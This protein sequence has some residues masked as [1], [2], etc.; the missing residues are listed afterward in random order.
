MLWQHVSLTLRFASVGEGQARNP[1]SSQAHFGEPHG[2]R[3][4]VDYKRFSRR[5]QAPALHCRS[6]AKP[7]FFIL[8]NFDLSVC[9]NNP[10]V[11]HSLDSSLY[12]REL[13]LKGWERGCSEFHFIRKGFH[14]YKAHKHPPT[15]LP[16][17]K[18]AV[19]IGDWGIV[20]SLNC[21]LWWSIYWKNNN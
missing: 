2:S 14:G 10:S 11:S 9:S 3:R 19:A 5:E 13:H 4:F 8:S 16:C 15:K 6:F 7:Q 21:N 20:S 17:V 1:Q 18:G 12:T